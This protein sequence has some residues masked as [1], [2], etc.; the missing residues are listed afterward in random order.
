MKSR[1]AGLVI[2][3]AVAHLADAARRT[4]T[5]AAIATSYRQRPQTV[6]DD[7]MAMASAVALTEAESW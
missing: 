4:W 7:E 5:G 6:E 3:R 1:S 2:R